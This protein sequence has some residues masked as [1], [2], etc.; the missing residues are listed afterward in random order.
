MNAEER[1]K[2]ALQSIARREVPD[3]TNLWP[4]IAARLEQKEMTNMRPQWRLIWTI[5]L[6][7]IGLALISGAAYALYH[8]FRDDAGLE[9][10]SQA[11]LVSEMNVTAPPAALPTATP[12][13]PAVPLGET[14]TRQGVAITLNWVYL[15]DMWQAIG[16]SVNGL[17]ND[18]RLD[19][20]QLDFGRLQ[21]EQ[22]S[23]AGMTLSQTE[24][25]LEGRYVVYQI[26]RDM[27]TFEVGETLTDV[28]VAIPLLDAQD[29]VV[30]V[31]RFAAPQVR[32]NL[33]PY[34]GGNVYLTR[35]SGVE[36]R[37]EWVILTPHQTRAK[38]CRAASADRPNLEKAVLYLSKEMDGI[39]VG[40]GVPAQRAAAVDE[41]D[42]RCVEVVFPSAVPNAK[43]LR[44]VVDGVEGESAD[45]SR[46]W[47]FVVL[48]LPQHVVIPGITP[49]AS[50]TIND[51]KVT[52]LQAYVDALRAA[53]AFRVESA[54]GAQPPA[55]GVELINAQG[56]MVNSG[57]F[58]MRMDENDPS[59]YLVSLGFEE[60]LNAGTHGIGSFQGSLHVVIDPWS[61]QG[62]QVFA[63]DLDLP[64]YPAL[65][66]TP[67]QSLVSQGLEMRL[68]KLEI[69]PSFTR[70]FLCYQK[71]S[72]ADW[73]IYDRDVTLQIGQ[74]QTQVQ[75]YAL[76]SDSDYGM[77]ERPPWATF[78]A[79][80]RC[81]R[82][83]FA[84]GHHQQPEMLTLS[85]HGLSQS[86]PEVIPH[87]EL[88]AANEILRQQG[89][90]I[91]WETFQGSGGGGGGP[92]VVQKPDGMQ[93]DEALEKF[94]QALG[95][96][97]EAENWVFTVELNP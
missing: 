93:D 11:G 47:Q 13:L 58:S 91:D 97:F 68:E 3:H 36:V 76:I 46:G 49:L 21:P 88:A 5:L 10:V 96:R 9:A 7:L 8:Y 66:L 81:V 51:V 71:P 28:S 52:L 60:P 37:L 90:Q 15:S 59:I 27:A 19:I 22:Y 25:G 31:F 53:V 55:V 62:G 18:L 26:V 73:G 64:L 34:G 95:Y 61:P 56:E 12:L 72:P 23:G 33:A 80:G 35:V 94:Y 74:T 85:V 69:T 45:S 29:R 87:E 40:D 84:L 57:G 70:V 54:A 38:L 78:S 82:L 77:N 79:E 30:D 39:W 67:R 44:L 4:Q 43:A 32:V 6:V 16:F 17:P 42:Q 86:M 83:G 65:T 24:N 2:M 89:I 1:L 50:Q 20:P 41:G 63:F 48:T 75:D 14:Q 92:R